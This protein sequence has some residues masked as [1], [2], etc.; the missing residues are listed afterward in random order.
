VVPSEDHE[1]ESQILPSPEKLPL[2]NNSLSRQLLLVWLTRLG[3][4]FS[5][6]QKSTSQLP[7]I[8][9]QDRRV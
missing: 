1:L 8:Q 9:L 5:A 7:T 6:N 4:L 3:R 2:E